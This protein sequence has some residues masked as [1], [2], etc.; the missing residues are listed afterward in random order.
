MPAR[1]SIE[2]RKDKVTEKYFVIKDSC[3]SGEITLEGFKPF[4]NTVWSEDELAIIKKN[5]VELKMGG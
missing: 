1:A 5:I 3:I 2:I 4:A